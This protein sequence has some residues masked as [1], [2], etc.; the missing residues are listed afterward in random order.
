MNGENRA[1]NRRGRYAPAKTRPAV[2]I[3]PADAAVLADL[4]MV[5]RTGVGYLIKEMALKAMG[6]GGAVCCVNFRH[7]TENVPEHRV[8]RGERG[9]VYDSFTGLDLAD[10][11]LTY[12]DENAIAPFSGASV[13]FV[14]GQNKKTCLLATFERARAAPPPV[15]NIDGQTA[16]A[17]DRAFCAANDLPMA[18]FS[19]PYIYDHLSAYARM[20]DDTRSTTVP[21][22]VYV[23]N[24]AVY[25]RRYTVAGRG[26]IVCVCHSDHAAGGRPFD[27]H[28]CALFNLDILDHL[29]VR[30]HD[31]L[32]R[33]FAERER[34]QRNG[35]RRAGGGYAERQAVHSAPVVA[36]VRRC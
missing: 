20:L 10:G 33:R 4:Q 5:Y 30:G 29:W 8:V 19:F 22:P 12:S 6:G 9:R 13:V 2:R 28:R 15:V 3:L 18:V 23:D 27:R 14:K 11:D 35:T 32:F 36:P 34:R 25:D 31:A 21:T 16:D 17:N 26:R 24:A 7:T 1:Y